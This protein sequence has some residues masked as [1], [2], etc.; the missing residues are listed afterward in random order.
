MSVDG[1]RD[2]KAGTIKVETVATGL[3]HPWGLAFLPDGR[4]LVT[5]RTGTLRLVS[6][7]GKLSPPL[8]GVPQVVVAGQGGLLDVAIDPDFKSN[9]LVYLTYSE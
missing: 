3:S 8:S 1:P 7:D 5:E 6:K 4:M 2:T 9:N